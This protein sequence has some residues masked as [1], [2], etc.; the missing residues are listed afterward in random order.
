MVPRDVAIQRAIAAAIGN[1]SGAEQVCK[2]ALTALRIG[3]QL[4]SARCSAYVA[5]FRQRLGA[6]G[7]TTATRRFLEDS[8]TARLWTSN[9]NELAVSRFA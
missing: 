1:G 9:V 7:P 8:S 4:K 5:S 2:A 6:M 3:E